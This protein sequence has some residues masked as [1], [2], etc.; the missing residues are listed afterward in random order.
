[1]NPRA[2]ARGFLVVTFP[3]SADQYGIAAS[4]RNLDIHFACGSHLYDKKETDGIINRTINRKNNKHLYMTNMNELVGC[5]S[6]RLPEYMDSETPTEKFYS[7]PDVIRQSEIFPGLRLIKLLT[8][9]YKEESY[10]CSARFQNKVNR[11]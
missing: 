3:V 7:V 2:G 11:F 4:G 5:L 1:M 10:L 8:L 9:I 6:H